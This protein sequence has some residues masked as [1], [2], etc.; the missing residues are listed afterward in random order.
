MDTTLRGILDRALPH[1]AAQRCAGRFYAGVT[2]MDGAP[3][4]VRMPRSVVASVVDGIGNRADMIATLAASA[5][6]PM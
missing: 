3:S 1:D 4:G 2:V 5:Y 6:I